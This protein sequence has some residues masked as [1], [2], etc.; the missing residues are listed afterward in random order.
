MKINKKKTMEQNKS[1]EAKTGTG[2]CNIRDPKTVLGV[3]S[4]QVENV[5]GE[6]ERSEIIDYRLVRCVC[7]PL[8]HS[9]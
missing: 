7:D 6:R 4:T 5:S 9:V 2:L 8:L 3:H 1:Q